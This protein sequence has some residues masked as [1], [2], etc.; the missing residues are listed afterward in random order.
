[1]KSHVLRPLYVAILVL[2][3]A[4]IVRQRLVPEGFGAHERGYMY[5]WHN[6]N[7]EQFWKKFPVKYKSSDYC[8]ECHDD[9]HSSIMRTPHGVIQCE[10]CHGPAL[11]HPNEPPRLPIDRG[12]AQCLRCHYPLPYPTSGRQN[13]KSVDPEEHNPGAECSTCHDPH[14]PNL[15]GM[16]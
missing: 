1:V 2:A 9:K 13:I 3:V 11:D 16:K 10:N 4:L 14:N 6:M 12:R 5:G 8:K 15:E 7:D